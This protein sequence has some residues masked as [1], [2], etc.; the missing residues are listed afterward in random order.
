MG[1]GGL[2]KVIGRW[3]VEGGGRLRAT[4]DSL[5]ICVAVR[6]QKRSIIR[7][8]ELHDSSRLIEKDAGGH[9]QTNNM[10]QRIYSKTTVLISS[11]IEKS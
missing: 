1:T 4:Q 5:C 7:R 9:F 10:R 3:R 8:R 2:L 6:V 11:G